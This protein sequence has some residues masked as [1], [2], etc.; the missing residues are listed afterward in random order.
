M[1]SNNDVNKNIYIE[2]WLK[3]SKYIND[4]KENIKTVNCFDILFKKLRI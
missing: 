3:N 1:Y 4:K 2:E